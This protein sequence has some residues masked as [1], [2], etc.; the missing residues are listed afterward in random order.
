[1]S[2]HCRV[3]HFIAMV[4]VMK[5]LFVLILVMV[6]WVQSPTAQQRLAPV[7]LPRT[8]SFQFAS[9]INSRAYDIFVSFPRAYTTDTA[10]RF[11]VIYLTDANLVFG[12][13]VQS[14]YLLSFGGTVPDALIVGIVRAGVESVSA[15]EGNVAGAERAFDLTPTQ[16]M[17][18]QRRYE[19]EYKREVRTGGAPAFLRVI[20]DELIPE[21]DRRY[22]TSGDRTFIGYSLG[23]LFGVYALFQSP[24]TFQRMILVSPSLWWDGNVSFKYEETYAASHKSLPL[25]IFMSMGE[26]ESDTML[27]PMRRLESV[28]TK[29][30]YQSLELTT[31]IFEGEQHLSTFPVAVTRGLMTVFAEASKR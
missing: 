28:L 3:P 12:M 6:V 19:R 27:G 20:K 10:A 21:V 22:R 25:R 24:E 4:N 31:R 15:T 11:P 18:E 1:M 9:R 23:G 30:H 5:R 14:H 13:T 2:L 8:E 16:D 17:E 7:T 29:R 26:A